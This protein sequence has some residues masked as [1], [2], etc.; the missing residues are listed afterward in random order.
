MESANKGKSGKNAVTT[1]KRPRR[2]FYAQN[3]KVAATAKKKKNEIGKREA[4]A[5]NLPATWPHVVATEKSLHL[6][7]EPLKN[8]NGKENKKITH[9]PS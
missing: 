1:A 4:P 2:N 3:R 7:G 5:G 9:T 6:P 8:N